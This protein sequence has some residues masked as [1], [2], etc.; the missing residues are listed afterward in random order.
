MLLA[1]DAFRG[2]HHMRPETFSLV[3]PPLDPVYRYKI[4]H[5]GQRSMVL[6]A[7]CLLQPLQYVLCKLRSEARLSRIQ[8]YLSQHS[9]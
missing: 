4:P 7:Y 5:A 3:E 2:L 8:L 1:A 6:T 9:L